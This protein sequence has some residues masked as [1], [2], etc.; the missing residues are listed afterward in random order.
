MIMSPRKLDCL[1]C[2][3]FCCF[4]G[5]VDVSPE[6]VRRLAD[7]L[8]MTSEEF[9]RMHVLG[10]TPA[11]EK[12]IKKGQQVCQFLGEDRKC[13]VYDARPQVC[14]SYHCWEQDDLVVYKLAAFV[15]EPLAQVQKGTKTCE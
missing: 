8:G 3:S 6:E 10:F 12:L 9:E 11:G 13:T 5:W 7:F 2:P 14:R 4:L 1:A 15:Q